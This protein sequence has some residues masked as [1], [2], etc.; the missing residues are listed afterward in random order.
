MDYNW[1]QIGPIPAN[2]LYGFYNLKLVALSYLIA[3]LA[4][5][6][7]LDLAGRLRLEAQPHL[8]WSWLIAGAI[9][10]G[11]GIWSMHFIGM[12]AFIMPMPMNYDL[13]WTGLSMLAA[14][15]AS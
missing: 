6:V 3:F 1:F 13:V 8:K 10:M 12:L 4:S 5:Y 2:A 15:L 11:A 7:A 9:A 14:I